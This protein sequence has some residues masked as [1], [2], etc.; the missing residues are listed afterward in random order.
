MVAQH[1]RLLRWLVG[2]AALL[3]L[4]G[5]YWHVSLDDAFITAAYAVT[6][7]DSGD[8]AWPGGPRFEGYSSLPWVLLQAA[9]IHLGLDPIL[10][11]K[12]VA[13][14]CGLGVLGLATASLP[15]SRGGDWTFAALAL[16]TPLAIWSAMPMEAALF[17]LLVSTSW[18]LASSPRLG[19]AKLAAALAVAACVVRPEGIAW[20]ALIGI[21]ARRRARGAA[22]PF[23]VAGLVTVGYHAARWHYFGALFPGPVLLKAHLS[24][25]GPV[26][27][28]LE[29]TGAL[30]VLV[31]VRRFFSLRGGAA[32][33]AHAP[34]LLSAATLLAIGGDWMGDA[35]ILLPGVVATVCGAPGFSE[36]AAS[37]AWPRWDT[38]AAI[39]VASGLSTPF[40]EPPRPRRLVPSWQRGLDTPLTALLEPLLRFAPPDASVQCADVGA[41]AHIPALSIVDGRGLVSP[42]FA[43]ARRTGDLSAIRSLYAS[44]DAPDVIVVSRF[45]PSWVALIGE[46]IAP[47]EGLD[48]WLRRLDAELVRYPHRRDVFTR[49]RGWIGAIRLHHRRE[50]KLERALWLRRARALHERFPA[51]P[52]LT[53]QLALGLAANDQLDAASALIEDSGHRAI[54]PLSEAPDSLAFPEGSVPV[55]Y[56]SGRGFAV[57][58]GGSRTSRPLEG[59]MRLVVD[60]EQPLVVSLTLGD[61]VSTHA[62]GGGRSELPIA[63]ARGER[64]TVGADGPIFV[65][66]R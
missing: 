41:V 56:V 42:L 63:P 11:A 35:R 16:F 28:L 24:W 2:A 52:W 1:K 19:S 47:Y 55:R 34:L 4:S 49:E 12:L 45:L 20:L 59:P 46:E 18:V 6:L 40:L 64:L 51:H 57:P 15:A 44:D 29:L 30:G 9:A 13:T 27:L 5:A 33:W 43:D 48:P 65:A 61:R 38:I 60:A 31:A 32:W 25:M 17:A 21:S 58:R 36:R 54:P 50:P 8:L 3:A 14:G 53:W 22:L 23:A 7:L 66:L 39:A 37:R 62:L 26:Q 10:V